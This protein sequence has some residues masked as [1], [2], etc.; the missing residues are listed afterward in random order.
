MDGVR[1][2]VDLKR[3]M[4]AKAVRAGL[5]T[6]VNFTEIEVC[7]CRWRGYCTA[8]AFV[9]ESAVLLDATDEVSCVSYK[10]NIH[11]HAVKLV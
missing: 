3:S 6:W 8:Y 7:S 10:H 9:R 4:S 5:N 11:T 2:A 1:T